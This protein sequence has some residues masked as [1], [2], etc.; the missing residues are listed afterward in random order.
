MCAALLTLSSAGLARAAALVKVIGTYPAGDVVTLGRNQ[1]FYLHLSYTSDH[2]VQ[3][4][5]EPAF[6]G[7][8][9][10][11]G[12]N[13]SRTYP[14]GSGEAVGWF[15][16]AEPG[17]QVDEVQIRAGDGSIDGTHLVAT[18]PVSVTGGNEAAQ[19]SPAPAWVSSLDA[20]DKAAQR[21]DY[22]K[23]M[24]TPTSTG[25]A[26]ILSGF[27]L[28]ACALGLIGLVAPAWGLWRWRGNWRWVAAMP[29][30]VMAFVVLRIVVAV[31]RDP[32]S[33][34]LWPVEI[35]MWGALSGGWMLVSAVARKLSGA[36]RS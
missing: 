22:Q 12:S 24:N 10:K 28:L 30:A 14:A 25:D 32:T 15:F 17:D 26:V 20:A 4:W 16:L 7:K 34:N 31:A 6:E 35:V 36:A 11:G 3:I 5:V 33:H 27:M 2:P 1:N 23:R 8:P 9:A 19:I 21:A 18:Y 13:P 29:M